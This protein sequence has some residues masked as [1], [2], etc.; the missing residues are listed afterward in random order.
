MIFAQSLPCC[1]YR[2]IG[3]VRVLFY[4][5]ERSM[6]GPFPAD[7]AGD[8]FDHD[9]F[10][11]LLRNHVDARGQVNYG[12]LRQDEAELN[13][14]IAGLDA[15]RVD[16]L[17][18]YEKLAL[19]L[20]AYNA[21]TLRL[22][23]NHAGV[24]SIRKIPNAWDREEWK[25]SGRTASLNQLEH[26][27]IRGNYAEPRVHFVLVCAARSCPWLRNEA[28]TGRALVRQ[29]TDQTARFLERPDA[30]YRREGDTIYVSEIL[31]WY[32]N[33][34]VSNAGSLVAFVIQH[35]PLPEES[36]YLKQNEARIVVQFSPYVWDLNGTW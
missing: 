10:D 15:A 4:P 20:N 18:E 17:G 25:L 12:T 6:T 36:A 34:F 27:W 21:F 29:L 31:D 14:Y 24:V 16:T 2:E 19:Y 1:S 22:L 8:R 33:D 5:P 26:D 9:V 7:T 23:L 30:G 11:R 32:K 28:Y 13:R 3:L 35:H